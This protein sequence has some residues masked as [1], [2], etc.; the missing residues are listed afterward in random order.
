M[1]PQSSAG[2]TFVSELARLFRSVGEGSALESIALKAVFVVCD[3]V[4][5]K[6]SCNSKERD[7]IRHLERQLKLWKM[8][9][10][11]NCCVKVE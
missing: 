11:M 2:S 7:H 3:L 10:W 4:L 6:P 9:P 8:E 5:Q 1:V